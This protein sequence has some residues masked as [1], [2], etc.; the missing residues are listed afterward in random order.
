M[1]A[2]LNDVD[3]MAVAVLHWRPLILMDSAS[4]VAIKSVSRK[5]CEAYS[6]L[7]AVISNNVYSWHEN[8]RNFMMTHNTYVT[9]LQRD[10]LPMLTRALRGDTSTPRQG[11]WYPTFR[12]I[13]NPK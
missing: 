8:Q 10:T 9:N 1:A 2:I 6:L 3:V 12:N 4:R 11:T 13:T 5:Y 7:M